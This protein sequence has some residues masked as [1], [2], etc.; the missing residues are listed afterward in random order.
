[1]CDEFYCE[2]YKFV[3]GKVC[4]FVCYNDSCWI[5]G[6][7]CCM[8]EDCCQNKKDCCFE[9]DGIVVEQEGGEN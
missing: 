1:M 7:C 9:V 4:K 2:G 8:V 3:F 5:V 6:C